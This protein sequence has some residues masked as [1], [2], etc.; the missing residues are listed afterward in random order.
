MRFCDHTNE[1]D[2]LKAI[3]SVLA[4]LDFIDVFIRRNFIKK[5]SLTLPQ[6]V[7]YL[8]IFKRSLFNKY[9]RRNCAPGTTALASLFHCTLG[10]C[11][12]S[13]TPPCRR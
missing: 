4:N 10:V 1:K 3:D 13:I 2:V 8:W 7:N 11:M 12:E 5:A 9:G 6:Y